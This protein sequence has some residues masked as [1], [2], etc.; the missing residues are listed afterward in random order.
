MCYRKIALTP[1][2]LAGCAAVPAL[3][4]LD[5]EARRDLGR[6]A[7]VA[8][9]TQPEIDLAGIPG[10]KAAGGAE[11]A[12]AVGVLCTGLM[13]TSGYTVFLIPFVCPAAAIAGGLIGAASAE[14]GRA[15][16]AAKQRLDALSDPALIHRALRDEVAKALAARFPQRQADRQMADTVL[17]VGIAS[18]KTRSVRMLDPPLQLVVEADVRVLRARDGKALFE[19]RL[20]FAGARHK[21]AEWMDQDAR[22]LRADIERAYAELGASI[23]DHTLLLYPFPHRRTAETELGRTTWGLAAEY[24]PTRGVLADTHL[25][26]WLTWGRIDSVRPVLSWEKFPRAA[27][28]EAAPGEMARV[29]N[30]SYDLVIAIDHRNAPL[31]VVYRRDALGAN[32]HRLETA[33]EP[34]RRYFWSVRA[35]FELDGEVYVTE[36]SAA[37]PNNALLDGRPFM[38][39]PAHFASPHSGSYRFSTP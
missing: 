4:T 20:G 24:P 37:S 39:S 18:I 9:A 7:V 21:L 3:P 15:V 10:S 30:V 34:A 13:A 11:G 2:I 19:G 31:R 25:I 22:A 27:D 33:L 14:S 1:L 26:D 29:R 35:R 16:D 23:V 17:E 38:T 5:A 36:W 12:V 8:R 32:S 6:V 28:V